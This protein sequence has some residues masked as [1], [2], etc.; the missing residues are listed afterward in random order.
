MKIV[1]I[2][3]KDT[4][5]DPFDEFADWLA[6]DHRKGYN[7]SEYLARI[8]VTSDELSDEENEREIEAAIDEIIKLNM[9]KNIEND[10]I[11]INYVKVE[12]EI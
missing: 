1:A 3:T 6:F 9:P 2:T 12:R 10:E 11:A 7:T 5:F 8:A 4:P